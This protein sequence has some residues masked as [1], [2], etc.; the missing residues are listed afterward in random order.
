MYVPM[1]QKHVADP[2]VRKGQGGFGVWGRSLQIQKLDNFAYPIANAASNF[3]LVHI[4]LVMGCSGG[5]KCRMESCHKCI[6]RRTR[7]SDEMA[8]LLLL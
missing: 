4:D 6:D 2:G 7:K 1:A 3:L 5:L 8:V